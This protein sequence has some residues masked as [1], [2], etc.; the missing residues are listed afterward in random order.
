VGNVHVQDSSVPEYQ[1]IESGKDLTTL[2]IDEKKIITEFGLGNKLT[3][4]NQ[5]EVEFYLYYW[6]ED[7]SGNKYKTKSTYK[8]SGQNIKNVDNQFT[9]MGRLGF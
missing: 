1:F 6:Y 2:M 9:E 8:R 5:L 7:V 3:H 4:L